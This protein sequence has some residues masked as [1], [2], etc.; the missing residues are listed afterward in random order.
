MNGFL[1]VMNTVQNS[2]ST[3]NSACTNSTFV[4]ILNPYAQH[5]SKHRFR[6]PQIAKPPFLSARAIVFRSRRK[7]NFP[8]EGDITCV[9]RSSFPDGGW[10]DDCEPEPIKND[11]SFWSN[12]M[13]GILGVQTYKPVRAKCMLFGTIC[14]P[15]YG[16]NDPSRLEL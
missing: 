8:N 6:T 3:H 15:D 5:Y 4:A 11:G 7:F 13:S 9:S 14:R 12:L 16:T 1:I 10:N 2:N